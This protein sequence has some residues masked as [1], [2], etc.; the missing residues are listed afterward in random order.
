M[1]C[2]A[3]KSMKYKELRQNYHFVLFGLE[4]SGS[5]GK[6]ASK[7]VREIGRKQVFVTGDGR[8]MDFL[9]QPVSLA[10]PQGNVTCLDE[11]LPDSISHVFQLFPADFINTCLP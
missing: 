10:I 3:Q 5:W 11:C 9:R 6:N 4:T 7:V 2:R 1:P 8:S